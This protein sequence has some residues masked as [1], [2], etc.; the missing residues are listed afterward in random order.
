MGD[1][2]YFSHAHAKRRVVSDESSAE[3]IP[4][5]TNPD[6]VTVGAAALDR[7]YEVTN[8]P[9]PDG[10]AYAHSVSESFGGVGAN[11]ATGLAKLGRDTALLARV[12]EDSMADSVLA[13]L[14]A[15]PVDHRL[16]R[17][18]P[19]VTTHCI[20][21]CDPA[22]DRMIL[23]AGDSTARLRIREADRPTLDAADVVF[24]TAYSPDPVTND[25]LDIAADPD[26]PAFAFD[27]S[28]PLEELR[29][30]GTRPETIARAIEESTLLV[31]GEVAATAYLDCDPGDTVD[32]L[33]GRGCSRGAVTFG[34]RGAT[35]FDGDDVVDVPAFDVET[36]DTTGA[37]DAFVASLVDRWLLGD[38]DPATAG[39]FA[40][41]AAALN[42]RADGA[43]GGLATGAEVRTFLAEEV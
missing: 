39:R 41:A 23:T 42:C 16:V 20:I 22:G 1:T 38:D 36:T 34:E 37:G 12:G 3:A 33:R 25:L 32:E 14:K 15:G 26:G 5:R 13:D 19:G 4:V 27:L 30:R 9:E 31:V 43:R 35:L 40:A 6:V 18:R 2:G 7:T 10:G 11:V 28:G 17:R 29:G 24:T 21:P 8:L